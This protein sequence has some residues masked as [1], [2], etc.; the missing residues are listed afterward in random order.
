[1]WWIVGSQQ[2]VELLQVQ[3]IILYWERPRRGR[4]NVK[5]LTMQKQHSSE[6]PD[7]LEESS[8]SL[9]KECLGGC[10]WGRNSS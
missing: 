10:C 9:R 4:K 2:S 6:I 8:T 5:I 1:M 7:C 3:R